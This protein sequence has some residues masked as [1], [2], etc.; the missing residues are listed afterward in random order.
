MPALVCLLMDVSPTTLNWHLNC[1][2]ID[3]CVSKASAEK[4]VVKVLVGPNT[5]SFM[6][7]PH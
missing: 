7:L 3:E 6:V 4:F 5:F 2:N 1:Q